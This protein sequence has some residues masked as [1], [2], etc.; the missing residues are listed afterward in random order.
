MIRPPF[1]AA[2][3]AALLLAATPAAAAEPTA[4]DPA[5]DDVEYHRYIIVGAGPAGLQMAHYLDS[6]GRDYLVL[7]RAASVGSFFE[8][9]PR[10]RQLISIN[11]PHAGS[12]ALDA[13]MRHVRHAR[14]E[15]AA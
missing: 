1:A 4:A 2:L 5:A 12:A 8:R 14:A 7:D 3:C 10:F 6:A 13:V 9:F 15:S 11:K